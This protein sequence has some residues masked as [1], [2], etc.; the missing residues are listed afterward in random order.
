MTEENG[1]P[2]QEKKAKN[3]GELIRTVKFVLFSI[4]SIYVL[5]YIFIEVVN[6]YR[7]YTFIY[8]CP[9]FNIVINNIY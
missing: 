1:I 7:N 8:Q 3:R 2:E 6:S 5:H 9:K 4:K